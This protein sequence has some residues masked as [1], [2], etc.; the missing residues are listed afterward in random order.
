MDEQEIEDDG[1][2]FPDD[3]VLKEGHLEKK[4]QNRTN[5]K[6]RW[7]I[8]FPKEIVYYD[9]DK[10]SKVKG[11]I[12]LPPESKVEI[13]ANADDINWK[14]KK[15]RKHVFI[16]HN[17]YRRILIQGSSDSNVKEW[18]DAIRAAIQR[19]RRVDFEALTAR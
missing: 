16:I 1:Q 14:N 4:G 10:K 12:L 15:N 17:A 8:L 13:V 6:S 7:F 5:W 11:Q 18:C 3:H 19:N 9:S 2:T